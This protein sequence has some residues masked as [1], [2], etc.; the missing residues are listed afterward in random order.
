MAVDQDAT[1]G[2]YLPSSSAQWTEMLASVGVANPTNLYLLQEPSG[3]AA[4][5]IGSMTLSVVA[6][7]F[8][9][10]QAVTGWTRKSIKTTAGTPAI[11]GNAAY[12]NVNANSYTVLCLARVSSVG[13]GLTRTLLRLGDTFNDDACLE[14]NT[15]PRLQVGEGDGT[16]SVGASNPTDAVTRFWLRIDDAGNTVDAFQGSTKIVGGTQACN[17]TNLTVGGD[18][19][20]T[21][22]PATTDYMYIAVW[23]TAISDANIAII[24]GLIDTGPTLYTVAGTIT[25]GGVAAANGEDVIIFADNGDGTWDEV[26]TVQIAGGAGAFT[27]SVPDNTRDY[28]AKYDDGTNRGVSALGTPV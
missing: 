20:E 22:M 19:N 23:S 7:G 6:A 15:T 10:Q 17:G 8:T 13:L 27:C 12:A 28:F 14:I 24:N 9:Y 3:T 5:S 18:D 4:D 21:N 26:D 16:R 1:S 11:L 25:I 2:K